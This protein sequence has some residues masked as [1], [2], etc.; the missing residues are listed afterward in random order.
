M[1]KLFALCGGVF[2]VARTDSYIFK[3]IAWFPFTSLIL[4]SKKTGAIVQTLQNVFS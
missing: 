2:D 4:Q 1:L 3:Q